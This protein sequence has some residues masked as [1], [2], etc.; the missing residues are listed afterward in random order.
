MSCKFHVVSSPGSSC[1]GEVMV[2]KQSC[3]RG[4]RC[5]GTTCSALAS[6]WQTPLRCILYSQQCSY[7]AFA[8]SLRIVHLFPSRLFFLD[9][10]RVSIKSRINHVNSVSNLSPNYLFQSHWKALLTDTVCQLVGKFLTF[11]A[12]ALVPLET[13]CLA[14]QSDPTRFLAELIVISCFKRSL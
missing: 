14:T 7:G 5:G 8:V 10:L 3:E 9:W 1:S 6:R 12:S 13:A 11:I 4:E 2:C